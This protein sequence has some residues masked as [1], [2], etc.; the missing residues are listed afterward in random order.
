MVRE[1]IKIDIGQIVKIG[2]CHSVVKYNMGRMTETDQGV[3]RTIQ[4]ILEEKI[5][6]GIFGQIRIIEVK[7]IE[8]DTEEIKE[9]IIMEEVEVGP[10]IDSILIMLEGMIEAVGGLDQVQELVPIEIE[11]YAINVGNMIILL[12]IVQLLK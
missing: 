7:I 1:I 6:E 9:M 2:E 4:V 5:L 3:I 11:F 10:G 12:R 8:V